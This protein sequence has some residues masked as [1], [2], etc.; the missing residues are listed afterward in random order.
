MRMIRSGLV[1][2]APALATLLVTIVLG[3]CT[4]EDPDLPLSSAPPE[5]VPQAPGDAGSCPLPTGF[6]GDSGPEACCSELKPAGCAYMHCVGTNQVCIQVECYEKCDSGV[7]CPPTAA[8]GERVCR[9]GACFSKGCTSNRDC[10]AGNVCGGS[11]R[12]A[13]TCRPASS[14]G[15]DPGCSVSFAGA[16]GVVASVALVALALAAARAR[17]R[18]SE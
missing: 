4:I 12:G 9:E 14:E 10:D 7:D 3:G 1:R 17:R 11:E 13:P 8:E 16:P 6:C 5:L 18:R 15:A 2:R